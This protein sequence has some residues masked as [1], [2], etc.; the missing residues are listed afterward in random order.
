MP[1]R[2]LAAD[3]S[4]L[5]VAFIWGVTFVMVQAAVRSYPVF[6]FLFTRFLL[7][8]IGLLPILWWRR[9]HLLPTPHQS[10]FRRQLAAGGLLGFFLFAGYAF[11][12]AGLQYT[13]PAKAGFITGLGVVFVPVLGLLFRRERPS[14]AV[15]LGIA[16][17]ALGLAFLSLSGVDLAQG[18][19]RG[20][21]LV[22]GCSIS[23]A[24]QILAVGQF[25][26][27]MNALTLTT[28]QLATVVVLAGGASL[29]FE[30]ATPWPP[31]G[32]PLFAAFFTGIL[33]TALAFAVQTAAQRFTTATHTALIFATEPVFAALASFVLIGERLGPA[34]ILGCGLILAGMVLAELGPGL[35]G[36][37]NVSRE[38]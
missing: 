34:Q 21:L 4:L 26:P 12:T 2:R 8:L 20:D 25:A 36:S 15:G 24:A 11:Q 6:A 13:T 14:P 18:V 1:S 16:A 5:F 30:P 32:Q 27:R 38:T 9:S 29:L 7:A 23:F 31:T 33:C 35:F 22:L 10:L 37:V 3:S 19:N 17:A 28:I